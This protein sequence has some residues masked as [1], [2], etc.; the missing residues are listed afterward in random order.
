MKR[1]LPLICL[2]LMCVSAES[3]EAPEKFKNPVFNNP[4][5]T[6]NTR[7]GNKILCF[8]HVFM[9][10]IRLNLMNSANMLQKMTKAYY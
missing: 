10:E 1:F 6:R 7:L 8:R 9:T 2:L 5:W 3:A 4:L